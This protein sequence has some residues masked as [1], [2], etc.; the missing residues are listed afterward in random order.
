MADVGSTR[1][2]ELLQDDRSADT[3]KVDSLATLSASDSFF[4]TM[5]YAYRCR[6]RKR[7]FKVWITIDSVYT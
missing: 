6:M 2:L 5:E 7:R 1:L 3:F 4:T